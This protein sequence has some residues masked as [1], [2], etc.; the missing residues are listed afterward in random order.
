MSLSAR[1]AKVYILN[2]QIKGFPKKTDLKLVEETVRTLKDGEY[3]AEAVFLKVGPNPRHASEC[4]TGTTLVGTQVAK[5]IESKNKN[6]PV[7]KYVVGAFG[8]RTLTI[9][10]GTSQ[11]GVVPPYV[12]PEIGD[13]PKSLALGPLGIT[14]NAAYFGFLEICNPKAGDTVVVSAAGGAV[15]SHVGQIAKIKGCKVI[16]ITGSDGK[17]NWLVNE[18]G[19]HHYINY[20]TQNLKEKLKEYAPNGV[21]CYFDNVGGEISSTVIYHLKR[22][23]RICICGATSLYYCNETATACEVQTP[24]KI[25]HARMEG[26][27]T[28][29]WLDR[30]SEGIRQNLQWIREGKLK[31]TETIT[32]GFENTFEAFI[33]TLEGKNIGNSI[34]AV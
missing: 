2:N 14:G 28:N 7:D 11:N 24:V 10:N 21:D 22:F 13:L 27:H 23:S 4:K 6:F 20:K 34:V 19:F 17:G 30:W 9:G 15:G 8:W 1:V 3:L 32:E 5:I 16:G 12:L 26:M 31:Y 25:Q 33:D 18:L 29:R